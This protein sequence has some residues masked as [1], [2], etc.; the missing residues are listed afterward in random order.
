MAG[1]E[2]IEKNPVG[3]QIILPSA[4]EHHANLHAGLL[5]SHEP[6]LTPGARAKPQACRDL[7]FQLFHLELLLWAQAMQHP[8]ADHQA[9]PGRQT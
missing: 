7:L 6:Q 3:R 2:V 8:S 4:G 9:C 1:A 5:L